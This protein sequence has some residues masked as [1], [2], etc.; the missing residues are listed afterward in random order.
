[1]VFQ[2]ELT[3]SKA[4]AKTFSFVVPIYCKRER[5][6]FSKFLKRIQFRASTVKIVLTSFP[7][8]ESY[9]KYN[10]YDPNDTLR[11]GVIELL[12]SLNGDGYLVVA[13]VEI[14]TE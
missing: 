8:I 9:H 12:A 11:S 7:K 10:T 2:F 1:M 13:E 6:R 3:T 5:K 14:S 4:S